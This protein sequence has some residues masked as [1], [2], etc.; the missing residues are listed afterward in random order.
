[1]F[2]PG[3]LSAYYLV[4]WAC[5]AA[6]FAAWLAFFMWVVIDSNDP[7]LVG[8]YHPAMDLKRDGEKHKDHN[9][10]IE[11]MGNV[12]TSNPGLCYNCLLLDIINS[13]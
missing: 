6:L 3:L 11:N 8:V 9:K 10:Y 5:L 12:L 4:F 7:T 1:M 2:F 13:F